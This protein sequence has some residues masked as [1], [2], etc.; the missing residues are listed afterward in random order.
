M[1]NFVNNFVDNFGQNF[2]LLAMQNITELWDGARRNKKIADL[3]VIR[4]NKALHYT[5]SSQQFEMSCP[6]HCFYSGP[7]ECQKIW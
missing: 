6:V 2:A 5:D 3:A 7:P 4:F 1:V